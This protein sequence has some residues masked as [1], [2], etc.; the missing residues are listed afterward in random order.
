[1]LKAPKRIVA[2]VLLATA[3]SI[4]TTGADGQTMPLVGEEVIPGRVLEVSDGGAMRVLSQGREFELRLYDVALASA[5][6]ASGDAALRLLRS[7]LVARR[8]EV[9]ILGRPEKGNLAV[10]YLALK[11]VDL[12]RELIEQGMA[13]Y[14]PSSLHQPELRA[15][16]HAARSKENGFWG[17]TS[18]ADALPG[19]PG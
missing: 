17:T 14:C 6:T 19:C 13:R 2:T 7:R 12:R 5:G 8:V 18:A 4:A 16:E 15:L 10:G 11:G 3:A 9:H 1:M